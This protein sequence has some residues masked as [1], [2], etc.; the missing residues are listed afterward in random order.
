[1]IMSSDVAVQAAM[2]NNLFEVQG[3]YDHQTACWQYSSSQALL[4]YTP[5]QWQRAGFIESVIDPSALEQW[6]FMAMMA[7]QGNSPPVFNVQVR[8]ADERLVQVGCRF[9]LSDNGL[10]L[11]LVTTAEPSANQ[12]FQQHAYTA[13][14]QSNFAVFWLNAQGCV[15]EANAAVCQALQYTPQELSALHVC[16]LDA[17]ED[18]EPYLQLAATLTQNGHHA[19]IETRF[20][21]KDGSTFPVALFVQSVGGCCSG[22]QL[23]VVIAED[24]TDRL[25]AKQALE[26]EHQRTNHYLDIAGVIMVTLDLEGNVTLLNR[27]ACQLLGVEQQEALGL[28]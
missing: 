16:D 17:A 8:R 25:A 4:G 6:R 23:Y 22:E 26:A 10:L 7:A 19:R 12:V 14:S 27:F 24:I 11:S 15:L 18:E 20:R 3:M 21:R 1:M 2:P 5:S 9:L 28:N 13:L